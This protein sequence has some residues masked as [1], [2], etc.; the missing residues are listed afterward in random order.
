M[1]TFGENVRARRKVMGWSQVELGNRCG[2]TP[3]VINHYEAGRRA[4]G[5]INAAKIARGLGTTMDHLMDGVD[6]YL[7]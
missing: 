1:S 6:L 7:T 3:D 2:L 5:I 4:P